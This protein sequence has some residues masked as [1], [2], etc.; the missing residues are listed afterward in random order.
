MSDHSEFYSGDTSKL[1]RVAGDAI[2]TALL[3]SRARLA[4]WLQSRSCLRLGM[5]P[6]S[7]H[8]VN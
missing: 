2:M 1:S 5:R 6:L 8:L 7:P 3:A 4:A